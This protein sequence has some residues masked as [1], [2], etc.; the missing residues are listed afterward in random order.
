MTVVVELDR[1]LFDG[2]V[3][4]KGDKVKAIVRGGILESDI[5]WYETQQPTGR[6]PPKSNII[7]LM[8]NPSRYTTVHV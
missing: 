3:K 6:Q 8:G 4:S 2:Y 7:F 1:S 5:D